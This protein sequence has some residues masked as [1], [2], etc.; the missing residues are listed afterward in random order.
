[1]ERL[2][3]EKNVIQQNYK[4]KSSTKEV[5][6]F[7]SFQD[8]ADFYSFDFSSVTPAWQY[9]RSISA[10]PNDGCTQAQRKLSEETFRASRYLESSSLPKLESACVD[11]VVTRFTAPILAECPRMIRSN[12]TEREQMR[13]LFDCKPRIMIF[14]VHHF[15]RLKIKGGLHIFSSP[16]QGSNDAQSFLGLSTRLTF[17]ILFSSQEGMWWTD[18]SCSGVSIIT[19]VANYPRNVLAHESISEA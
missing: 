10:W 19:W 11:A 5:L 3:C 16:C 14:F 13:Y 15:V 7:N 2:V 12:V 18:G 8:V 1:M 4:K 17:S 9:M 6:G